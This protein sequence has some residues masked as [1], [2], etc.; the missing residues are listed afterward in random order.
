M[1]IQN[2]FAVPVEPATAWRLLLDVPRMARCMPGATLTAARED[3]SY[4]GNVVV[5]LGPVRLAFAGEARI[6]ELDDAARRAKVEA[7]GSDTKGRGSAQAK[8]DFALLPDG[9]GTRVEVTTDLQLTG[10]VAQYGRG[11]GLIKEVANQLV[12]EFAGNLARD[13]AASEVPASAAPVAESAATPANPAPEAPAASAPA[14]APAPPAAAP[15][16]ALSILAKA[17]RALIGGWLKRLFTG[18]AAR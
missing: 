13:I 18:K 1:Q 3:R 12:G 7:K 9:A 5:K 16:S 8:L 10:S 2:S 14:P 4:A 15:V 11:A 6:T 17:L